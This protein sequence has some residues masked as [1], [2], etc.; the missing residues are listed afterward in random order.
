MSSTQIYTFFTFI[1]FYI[2]KFEIYVRKV[3]IIIIEY[4]Y[5]CIKVINPL[6]FIE[7]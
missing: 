1:T 4:R 3:I 5:I 2:I 6:K 7:F